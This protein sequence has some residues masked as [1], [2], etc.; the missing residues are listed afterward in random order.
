MRGRERA[1]TVG[2]ENDRALG[3]R[4]LLQD[5]PLPGVEP[6]VVPIVLNDTPNR[7][8]FGFPAALPMVGPGPA[9]PRDDENV[10]VGCAHQGVP[11]RFSWPPPREADFPA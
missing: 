4:D 11:G 7:R 10:G 2:D 1:E 3:P 5:A 9:E 6:G 8:K